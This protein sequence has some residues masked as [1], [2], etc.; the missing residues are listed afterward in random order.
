[1]T[2]SERIER[3]E[4]AQAA[5]EEFLRP[6]FVQVEAEYTERLTETCRRRP[7]SW[8]Q[9]IMLATLL[10]YTARARKRIEAIIDDGP[11]ALDQRTRE[12]HINRIHPE[13]RK[14][15]GV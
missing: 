6:A 15:L 13:R 10:R 9:I 3:A 8:L 1:M 5:M 11:I 7:W 2:P 12:I 4:R 14:V